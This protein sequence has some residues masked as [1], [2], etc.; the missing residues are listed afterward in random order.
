MKLGKEVLKGRNLVAVGA[1]IGSAA[2][3]AAGCGGEKSP[4]TFTDENGETIGALLLAERDTI[5]LEEPNQLNRQIG[6]IKMGQDVIARCYFDSPQEYGDSVFVDAS[7][8]DGRTDGYAFL[9][10]TV[11]SKDTTPEN[12]FNYS[13]EEMEKALPNCEDSSLDD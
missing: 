7:G 6:I 2:L 9:V 10:S 3:L 1:T 8:Q 5:I 11:G 4:P 12:I 13:P